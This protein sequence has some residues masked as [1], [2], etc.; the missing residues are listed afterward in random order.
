VAWLVQRIPQIVESERCTVY[1]VDHKDRE[2]LALQGDV[3]IKLPLGEP[4]KPLRQLPG[5]IDC[6]GVV[7]CLCGCFC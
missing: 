4:N 2:L 5:W 7:T 3:N 1:L 6:S